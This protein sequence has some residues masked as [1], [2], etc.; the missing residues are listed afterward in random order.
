MLAEGAEVPGGIHPDIVSPVLVG[1]GGI[2]NQ[3]VGQEPDRPPELIG[4]GGD[5]GRG[6]GCGEVMDQARKLHA[7]ALHVRAKA[8][9]PTRDHQVRERKVV[10]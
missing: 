2:R 1:G 7:G 10:H 9:D 6:A 5:A 8:T 3:D 4:Q